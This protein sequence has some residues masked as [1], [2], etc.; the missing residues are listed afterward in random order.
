[1]MTEERARGRPSSRGLASDDCLSCCLDLDFPAPSA[2]RLISEMT[3][4]PRKVKAED[5]DDEVDKVDEAIKRNPCF[6]PIQ[7]MEDCLLETD[8]NFAKCQP[9]IKELQEC[10]KKHGPGGMSASPSK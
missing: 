5:D 1:M 3:P 4:T 10:V 9:Q 8:R 2:G 7:A 6:E